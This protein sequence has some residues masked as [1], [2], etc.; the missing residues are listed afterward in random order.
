MSSFKCNKFKKLIKLQIC[1]PPK[2]R[3]CWH[4]VGGVVVCWQPLFF[5]ARATCCSQTA[6]SGT[7]N[8]GFP[9][10]QSVLVKA[11]VQ[12]SC[13]SLLLYFVCAYMELVNNMKLSGGPACLK[14]L[15]FAFNLL[16]V[17]SY[18]QVFATYNMLLSACLSW[19]S[20]DLINEYITQLLVF[21]GHFLCD[22]QYIIISS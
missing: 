5:I 18:I 8:S 20:N 4:E 15:L 13:S 9:S 10:V 11:A 14:Y 21:L 7:L 3:L 2:I 17:V 19:I 6:T 1:P 12:V 16:F 22:K